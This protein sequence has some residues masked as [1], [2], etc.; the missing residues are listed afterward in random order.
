MATIGLYDAD[1]AK[2]TH[3]LFNLDLMKLSTYYKNQRHLVQL[4]PEIDLDKYSKIIYRKDYY[5]GT[6]E[7]MKTASLTVDRNITVC[8]CEYRKEGQQE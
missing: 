3:V 7:L 1:M 5:D 8:Q 2:Y 4:I 6:F